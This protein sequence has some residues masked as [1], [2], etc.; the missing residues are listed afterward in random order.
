MFTKNETSGRSIQSSWVC[1]DGLATAPHKLYILTPVQ[2]VGCLKHLYSIYLSRFVIVIIMP[3]ARTIT[4][5]LS[6]VCRHGTLHLSLVVC[7]FSTGKSTTTSPP[8][9]QRISGKSQ[10]IYIYICIYKHIQ[11]VQKG[12]HTQCIRGVHHTVRTVYT[13]RTNSIYHPAGGTVQKAKNRNN[14]HTKY[15]LCLETEQRT[16]DNQLVAFSLLNLHTFLQ[17]LPRPQCCMFKRRIRKR[18]ARPDRRICTTHKY[19]RT[20]DDNNTATAFTGRS[21]W[22]EGWKTDNGSCSFTNQ[23]S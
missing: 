4:P 14:I 20:Y 3:S 2:Q 19:V 17:S 12:P 5:A 23:T 1:D 8:A 7:V 13:C 22:A 21:V 9:V 15:A 6:A 11:S 10:A 16:F 18:P